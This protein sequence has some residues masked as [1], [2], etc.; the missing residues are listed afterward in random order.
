MPIPVVFH[1][2]KGRDGHLLMEAMSRVQGEI[3]C[4]PNNTEKY[5]SFSLENLRFI[6][7][8][9]FLL[10]SLHSLVKGSDPQSFKITEKR[11]KHEERRTLLSKK[12]I[13]PYEYMVCFESFGETKLPAEEAFHSKLNGKSI[14][15][16]E[17]VQKPGR[18]SRFVLDHRGVAVS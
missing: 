14:T 17:E 6:D 16:E 12:G 11:Y 3:K 9:N 8:V 18:L 7:S 4:I 2:L 13:Y 5:I 1:N 15:K 10:N